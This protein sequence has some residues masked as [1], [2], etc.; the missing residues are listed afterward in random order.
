[1]NST[2]DK[3]SGDGRGE[4][5]QQR[6]FRYQNAHW[7]WLSLFVLVLDQVSKRLII[8][9]LDLFDRIPLV[10][11]LNITRMHN[12]GAAFSLLSDAPPWLF[13][14]LAV[15]VSIGIIIWLRLHPYRERLVAASLSL[16]LGGALGNAIDR[17]LHGYVIDFIDFHIGTWHYPA[18]NFADCA[19]VIGAVLM[20]VDILRPRK[21]TRDNES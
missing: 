5:G 4:P 14:G 1:M 17:V 10:G 8:N 9:N 19:I 6:G 18:F 12:T 16:I 2:A 21:K 7:L 3:T 15:A 13:A 20:A 11:V